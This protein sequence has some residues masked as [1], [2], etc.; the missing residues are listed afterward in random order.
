MQIFLVGAGAVTSRLNLLF[1]EHGHQ[2]AAQLAVFNP[3]HLEMFPC[4]ALVVVAPEA[5][6][7]PEALKQAVERGKLVIVVSA[8][9]DGLGAWANGVG[10]TA[11]AYPPSSEE[12]NLLLG[13][14]GRAAEG[15]A[16][17]DDAYRRTVLG[18]DLAARLQS[19]MA[20]RK[21][22]ITSPK[23]GVGKTTVAVNL[24]VLFAL[25][26]V[27]TY[28]VDAD[29][30]AGAIQYH[31][32]LQQRKAASSMLSLLRQTPAA[33][34]V[35]NTLGEVAASAA[36]LSAFTQVPGL[37]TLRVLTGLVSDDLAD[38]ALQD[39]ARITTV[40]KGLYEAGVASGGVVIMD[41]G[42]NPAHIV[43]RAAL[44]LAEGIGIVI[45]PE[46]PDIAEAR[47]WLV[48]MFSQL[49]AQVGRE[50]AHEFL[51][52]RIKLCYNQV[53]P[54]RKLIG[55]QMLLDHLREGDHIDLN[56]V[57]NGVLPLVDPDI[58]SEAVNGERAEDILIWR[59]KRERLEELEPFS[60]ALV[61]YAANFIPS[62]VEGASRAGLINAPNGQARTGLF[63]RKRSK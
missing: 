47:R 10:V 26:G 27:T 8:P 23:G 2:V 58:A 15:G 5:S 14:L 48:R 36:Y 37:P 21:I 31:L 63:G 3:Q 6:T 52:S 59:R 53:I 9:G 33:G 29:A 38:A 39:E 16:A 18:S 28:L 13:V 19:G 41:V 40:L 54:G 12:Q 17:G 43:H 7:G 1:S 56:L 44:R 11:Y 45:K 30:N 46:I 55:H 42:I 22:A 32:R 35:Q 34:P 60:Q 49:A 4:E 25:S 20:V 61:A 24:A 57:P 50:A 51:G 62:I